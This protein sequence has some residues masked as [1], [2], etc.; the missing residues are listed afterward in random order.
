MRRALLT[1]ITATVVTLAVAVAAPL[2]GS[3]VPTKTSTDPAIVFSGEGNNLNAYQSTPPFR[4]QRVIT[5]RADD[6]KG[7]DINAQICFFPGSKRGGTRW[8]IAGEDTGQPNPPQ[9]WGIFE[10]RGHQIGKLHARKIGK[11][12]PTYQGS[13][14]NAE[15]YG[16]G[17]LK[18]GRVV[19]T[20]VGNQAS[21]TGDGQLIVWFPPFESRDVKYCKVNVTL[22]TGQGMLVDKGSV[23]VAQARGDNAGI[24]R[25]KITDLPTSN[26]A[27][28]G[29]DG[30]DATGAPMATNVKS[31]IFIAPSKANTLA[32]PNAIAKGPN[33]HLFV[34]S[35]FNGVIAEFTADGKFI[36]DILKPPAGEVLGEKPFST[37]TPLGVGVAPD[38]SVFFADIGIV[39]TKDGIG[40][41]RGT[42]HVR[43]I[44]F[45]AAG[46]P[47]APEIMDSDLAFPDGIGIWVP[48]SSSSA[49]ANT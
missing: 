28:G 48:P 42:G 19:T 43:R 11:L 17:F 6:P 39:A 40:P 44:A 15:N 22:T 46:N 3:A 13:L 23:Y 20:D 30:K 4:R 45:D 18:D 31:T 49:A 14:D 33:G 8:F 36:R 25:Y 27:S 35:V 37:G 10:L 12:T 41:G 38:G 47:K 29:C 24:S 32:T 5:T 1:I 21:G 16:C 7:L 9:G 26:T 34:T 2:A